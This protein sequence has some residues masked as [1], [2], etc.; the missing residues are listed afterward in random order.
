MVPIPVSLINR[1]HS[2]SLTPSLSPFLFEI[3]PAA[4]P[5]MMQCPILVRVGRSGHKGSIVLLLA[6]THG[7]VFEVD[8][9]D[10]GLGKKE[11]RAYEGFGVLDKP[12][13]RSAIG[14][15]SGVGIAEAGGWDLIEIPGVVGEPGD[16]EGA[17]GVLPFKVVFPVTQPIK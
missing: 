7:F 2:G 13:V 5:I 17:N 12:K 9:V 4:R 3:L 6:K 11:L 8:L 16:G 15:A 14:Y 10:I 1:P